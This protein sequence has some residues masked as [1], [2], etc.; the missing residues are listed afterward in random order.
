M[1]YLEG[2]L[3]AAKPDIIK[4]E[5]SEGQIEEDNVVIDLPTQV[6]EID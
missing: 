6:Q 2:V 3:A 5:P 4:I 1:R